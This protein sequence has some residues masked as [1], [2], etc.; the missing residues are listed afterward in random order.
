MNNYT[1]LTAQVCVP[2]AMQ[3]ILNSP[4]NQVQ[5]F[6][7]AGH[8]CAVMGYWEY[9]PIA[10][11]YHVPISVTGFEPVDLLNG[12]TGVV[13]QLESGKAEVENTY[14]R[15]VTYEGNR[16]AQDTIKR[17]YINCDRKWRGIGIIPDSGWKLGPEFASFDAEQ[18]FDIQNIQAEEAPLC[19]AG[20]IL[21]GKKKPFS[22]P[23]FGNLCTPEHPLGAPMVSAEG[24]C[25]AY[26]LY[27]RQ[28]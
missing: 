1:N 27:K 4:D 7:A 11:R 12:I 24:A 2:P 16:P 10:A 6:L 18:R 22:C 28:D 19:I 26:Y 8:V 9:P 25:A 17:V 20:E 23:A 14:E 15:A 5:A 3:A 13:S 21:Q